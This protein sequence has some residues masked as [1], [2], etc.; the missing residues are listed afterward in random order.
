VQA[1]NFFQKM[2]VSFKVHVDVLRVD[3]DAHHHRFFI[4]K[5]I[6]GVIAEFFKT[7]SISSRFKYF[8]AV[9]DS[10]MVWQSTMVLSSR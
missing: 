9:P 4:A 8:S 7:V 5:V 6:N 1:R 10:Y 2:G 3:T